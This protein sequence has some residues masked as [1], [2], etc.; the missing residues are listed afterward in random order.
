MRK[1]YNPKIILYLLPSFLGM[2]FG[3]LFL[4]SGSTANYVFGGIFLTLSMLLIVFTILFVP[5]NYIIDQDGIHIFYSIKKCNFIPWKSVY[6]IALRC[7]VNFDF[8]FFCKDY[9][10][11][12]N[13]MKGHVRLIDKV[14]KTKR[15]EAEIKKHWWKSIE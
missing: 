10:I 1:L 13:N 5:R 11:S 7:D 4:V 6:S 3:C 15:T 12:H 8:F 9:I 2:V 14:T